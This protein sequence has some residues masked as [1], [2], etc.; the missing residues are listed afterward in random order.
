MYNQYTHLGMMHK[1]LG[2]ISWP[3]YG[4]SWGL[5]GGPAAVSVSGVA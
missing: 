3:R 2:H 4:G 1:V 5:L